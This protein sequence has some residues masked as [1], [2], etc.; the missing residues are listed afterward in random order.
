MDKL[1]P[2]PFCGE[3]VRLYE[4]TDGERILQGYSIFNTERYNNS[5]KELC[6]GC[7]NCDE[8]FSENS[9]DVIKAWNTRA[10]TKEK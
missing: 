9:S 4:V 8:S 1:K 10:S 7:S 5:T 2:C 6:Y 3:S